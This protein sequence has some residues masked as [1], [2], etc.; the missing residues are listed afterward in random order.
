MRILYKANRF[1]FDTFLTTPLISSR[2]IRDRGPAN[3]ATH[4]REVA[5][6]QKGGRKMRISRIAKFVAG[7]AI[8]LSLALVGL[9]EPMGSGKVP[10]APVPE[11]L[12]E[13]VKAIAIDLTALWDKIEGMPALKEALKMPLELA[14][15][16]LEALK[17]I[18]EPGKEA[19]KEL[20]VLSL[21]LHRIED[22]FERGIGQRLRTRI[23]GMGG[24]ERDR[25]GRGPAGGPG[26]FAE[27]RN[28]IEAYLRGAMSALSPEEAAKFRGIIG[29]LI[30]GLREEFAPERG[31]KVG[32]P[33]P[34][35]VE[36]GKHILRIKALSARLDLFLIRAIKAA[37]APTG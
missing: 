16:S 28:W 27:V 21:A 4:G 29:G 12:P 30:K 15:E 13:L 5:E 32:R 35:A 6:N 26:M 10:A 37:E 2:F 20:I 14:K 7:T 17:E 11:K 23:P 36:L 34:E 3:L 22:V 19:L 9:A 25:M 8:A 1:S 24:P 31:P 18:G 33:A